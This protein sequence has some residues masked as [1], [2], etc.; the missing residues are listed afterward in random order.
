M[1]SFRREFGRTGAEVS[2]EGHRRYVHRHVSLKDRFGRL[3]WL[4]L[5]L[6]AQRSMRL[7]L[8]HSTDGIDP[9]R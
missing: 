5:W 8:A 6:I 3:G 9:F 1:K 2:L 4:A 7:W